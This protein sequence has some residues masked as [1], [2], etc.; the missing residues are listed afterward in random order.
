MSIEKTWV[1]LP[2]YE[3]IV[4]AKEDDDIVRIHANWGCIERL[5][6]NFMRVSLAAGLSIAGALLTGFV[7]TAGGIFGGGLLSGIG[8]G[9][10][11]WLSWEKSDQYFLEARL[12]NDFPKV[13]ERAKA[14]N[15]YL[16]DVINKMQAVY[17]VTIPVISPIE[18][19][20]DLSNEDNHFARHS[21]NFVRLCAAG[22]LS[23]AGGWLG[24]F[25]PAAGG[26]YGGAILSGMGNGLS[27]WL[28]FEQA[29]EA[30]IRTRALKDLPHLFKKLNNCANT[31]LDLVG[32]I[33][34]L[35]PECLMLDEDL[36][37]VNSGDT[38]SFEC[39]I[40]LRYLR[41]FAYVNIAGWMSAAGSWMGGYWPRPAG[42][43]IGGSLSGVAN[44]CSTWLA[45]EKVNDIEMEQT[46]L[47]LFPKLVLTVDEISRKLIALSTL[48]KT[49]SELKDLPSNVL[50]I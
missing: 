40:S 38:T 4:L 25:L 16:D 49:C 3:P 17:S 14:I 24:G 13:F 19:S 42:I 9:T 29:N 27:T 15:Q 23:A 28:A 45:Q 33:R 8:N 30:K 39:S 48:T 31:L 5:E 22:S 1:G 32:T 18:A 50:E 37:P 6:R 21:R 26:I 47:K 35:N 43:I 34:L 11:A 10:S 36:K 44:V 12:I 20:V 41:N 46:A 2:S 7:P